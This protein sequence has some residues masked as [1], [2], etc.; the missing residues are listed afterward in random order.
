M[1]ENC[2][3]ERVRMPREPSVVRNTLRA[4]RSGLFD[5]FVYACVLEGG[6]K[7]SKSKAANEDDDD[8]SDASETSNSETGS[9]DEEETATDADNDG[10]G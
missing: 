8:D 6:K 3:N 5:S 7:S 10:T 1:I 2:R 9:D 4:Q